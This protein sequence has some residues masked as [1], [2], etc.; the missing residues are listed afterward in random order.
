M[1]APPATSTPSPNARRIGTLALATGLTVV[2]VTSLTGAAVPVAAIAFAVWATAPY[3]A[4]WGVSRGA[5]TAWIIGGAGLAG[6]VFEI[7]IRLTVFVVPRG[8]TAAVAL[9]F[10]PVVIGLVAMPLGA[11]C[12]W[13]AGRLWTRGL[14][15]RAAVVLSTIVM[16]AWTVVGIAW[17]EQLPTA[18]LAR[19]RALE[20]IGTPRVVTGTERWSSRPITGAAAWPTAVDITGDG[21]EA[22]ATLAGAAIEIRGLPSLDVVTRHTLSAPSSWSWSSR[23]S[24]RAPSQ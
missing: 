19:Q 1:S 24:S 17:P 8:S 16:A 20:A 10:S 22:L 3:L 14:A 21:D 23:R 7:A 9:I 4:L 2:G 11:A 12:G 6:L 18:R 5:G 13:L 15:A